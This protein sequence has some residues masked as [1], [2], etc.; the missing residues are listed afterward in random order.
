MRTHPGTTACCTWYVVMRDL[1]QI[2]STITP[3]PPHISL[4][5]TYTNV[6]YKHFAGDQLH[7]VRRDELRAAWAIFTPLLHICKDVRDRVL[8]TFRRRP[9]A[10]C[11]A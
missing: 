4:F 1:S 8:H 11:A 7:F 5:K 6:C 2:V 9:A 10:L 3:L